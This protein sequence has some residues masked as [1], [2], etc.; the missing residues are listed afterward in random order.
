L[1]DCRALLTARSTKDRGMQKRTAAR[2]T[3]RSEYR[4]LL[5]E[6]RA[7][8]TGYRAL[9]AKESTKDRGM[10]KGTAAREIAS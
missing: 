7:L 3:V 2:E 8:L 1:A 10:Q 9:L 6:Y 5:P 4:A